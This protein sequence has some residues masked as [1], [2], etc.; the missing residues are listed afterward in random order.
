MNLE[1]AIQALENAH[2]AG[3]TEA[4]TIIANEIKNA[5]SKTENS[6][7]EYDLQD[8][9]VSGMTFGLSNK[10]GAL[11]EATGEFIGDAL[12]PEKEADFGKSYDK[13]IE[14]IQQ[15]RRNYLKQNPYLGGG[16]EI[17]GGVFTGG[18]VIKSLIKSAPT[19]LGRIG[20]GI[21]GGTGFGA[22]GGYGFSEKEPIK[23]TLKG[24]AFGGTLGGFIPGATSVAS[25]IA[26]PIFS[27]FNVRSPAQKK[28]AEALVGGSNQAEKRL[29]RLGPD[30]TIADLTPETQLLARDVRATRVPGTTIAD[31]IYTRRARA[32]PDRLSDAVENHLTK[33]NDAYTR[34]KQLVIARKQTANEAYKEANTA[35]PEYSSESINELIKNP[36]IKSLIKRIK[37]VPGYKDL[38][39]NNPEVL[40]QVYK[41]VGSRARNPGDNQYLNRKLA[42]NLREAM[43]EENPAYGKALQQFS[44]DMGLEDALKLGRNFLKENPK[45]ITD[46]LDNMS[47]AEKTEYLT[48]VADA[49]IEKIEKGV[50]GRDRTTAL[51][52][53]PRQEK[54]LERLFPSR[55]NF[56][57]FKKEILREA[58][59]AETKKQVMLGS[60]TAD[61]L[62]GAKSLNVTDAANVA[63]DVGRGDAIGLGRQG[64]RVAGNIIRRPNRETAKE[65]AKMLFNQDRDANIETLRMLK[66][67]PASEVFLNQQNQNRLAS[68]LIAGSIAER[69]RR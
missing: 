51:F 10:V 30:A 5:Q 46:L 36:T 18:P 40:D 35:I 17:V 53:S 47:G 11:G 67:K 31:K 57:E 16:A 28:L 64:A 20:R 62:A 14:R 4:A 9:I 15:A 52:G 34:G 54:Q 63:I 48:G 58:E 65:L 69:N 23:E 7:T 59:F 55:K 19:T 37:Q 33:T 60:Q 1:K 50:R 44:D 6:E 42:N 61:K 21:I 68:A 29:N 3:D 24:G 13:S 25:K 39:D 45:R 38:P 32:Q 41:F 26:Q 27:R 43:V 66:G 56:L 22:L 49:L 8:A 2:E 12:N